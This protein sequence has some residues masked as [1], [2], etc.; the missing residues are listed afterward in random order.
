VGGAIGLAVLATIAA[1]RTGAL[2][3]SESA[4]SALADGYGRAILVGSIIAL[5]VIAAALM[6]PRSR[7][8]HGGPAQN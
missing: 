2:D 5:G 8:E 6:I 4:A 3:A 7:P 1:H